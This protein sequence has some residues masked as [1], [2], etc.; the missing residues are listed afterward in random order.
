M[1]SQ[2]LPRSLSASRRLSRAL[3]ALVVGLCA[4]VLA[5]CGGEDPAQSAVDGS[6]LTVYSS[7]PLEGPDRVPALDVLRGERI[8]LQEAGG[9]VGDYRVRLVSLDAATPEADRWDPAQISENARRAGDDESAVAYVGEFHTGSSA[10]SVPL[11]NEAGIL[12]V[13]P[14]DSAMALTQ[15]TLSV[16]DS[17]GKYY[18]KAEDYG[19]TFKRLVPGDQRQA[20]AQLDWMRREGVERLMILSDEDPTGLGYAMTLRQLARGYGIAVAGREDID[21]HERDPRDLIRKIQ[22][23]R[24]DAVFYAGEAHEGAIRL[25]QDL[26]VAEPELKLFAP[27]SLVDQPFIDAVGAPAASATYVT[28]PLQG[29]R[30][31]PEPAARFVRAYEKRYRAKP[32]AEALY[33]YEAM[34]AVLAAIAAAEQEAGD[35]PLVRADVVRAFRALRREGTVLGDYEFGPSG[36]PTLHRFG[37]YR[38]VDGELVYEHRLDG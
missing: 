33:G 2:P 26:T 16:P 11:L 34:S 20:A 12:Q 3:A 1:L 21:P 22:E 27:G 24:A 5:G 6:E 38:V 37:A 31:Y 14:I 30:A 7:M 18:P 35:D 8:A 29:L 17:P 32:T 23:S 25:W 19:R 9:R 13:S 10:I 28:R 36:D 15:R 4:L